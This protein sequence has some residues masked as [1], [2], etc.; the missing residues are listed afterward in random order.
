MQRRGPGADQRKLIDLALET[1]QGDA[2]FVTGF[3][4]EA[5]LYQLYANAYALVMPSRQ[6]G[7][8]LVYL[9]AMN[10]AKACIAC[11]D[12]GGEEVV[13]DGVTGYLVEPHDPDGLA[14]ALVRASATP[15]Q[16][17]TIAA[18]AAHY[19]WDTVA[20]HTAQVYA[21]TIGH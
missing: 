5:L 3:V 20:E 6:E 7:F 12:D 15:W 2:V 19:T 4:E 8:G 17:D 21:Q 10:W 14:A 13:Q 11:R 18:T 1:S 16:A 9:E